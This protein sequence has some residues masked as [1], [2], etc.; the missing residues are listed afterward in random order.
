MKTVTLT[1]KAEISGDL[2]NFVARAL[3]Y[4]EDDIDVVGEVALVSIEVV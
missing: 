2:D 4:I 1:I 3:D